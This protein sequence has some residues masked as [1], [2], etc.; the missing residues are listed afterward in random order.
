MEFAGRELEC[1]VPETSLRAVKGYYGIYK[2]SPAAPNVA[3]QVARLIFD[4]SRQPRPAGVRAAGF[5]SRQY[6]FASKE[7][8]VDFKVEPRADSNRVS[9]VGQVLNSTNPKELVSG[10]QVQLRSGETKV[11]ETITNQYGEF[12]IE[13]DDAKDGDLLISIAMDAANVFV[14]SLTASQFVAE[15]VEGAPK[16]ARARPDRPTKNDKVLIFQ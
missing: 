9:L 16:T 11:A 15:P 3:V 7:F 2:P 1:R 14:A 13:F 4:S 10:K 8:T 5:P 6:L 12:H